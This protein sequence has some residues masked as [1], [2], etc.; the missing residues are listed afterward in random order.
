[1]LKCNIYVLVRAYKYMFL[2]ENFFKTLQ[3]FKYPICYIIKYF[4]I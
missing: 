1:M 2:F 3:Y 4:Y